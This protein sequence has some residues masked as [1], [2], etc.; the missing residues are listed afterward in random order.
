MIVGN[1]SEPLLSKY[2]QVPTEEA[3]AYA[4]A[5]GFLFMEVS[6]YTGWNVELAFGVLVTESV[7]MIEKGGG[8]GSSA[9]SGSSGGSGE[10]GGIGRSTIRNLGVLKGNTDGT[11]NSA[12]KDD[13]KFIE[14]DE[15]EDET[16]LAALKGAFVTLSRRATK[17]I[18]STASSSRSSSP[19]VQNRQQEQQQPSSSIAVQTPLSPPM[20]PNQLHSA[21]SNEIPNED[22]HVDYDYESEEDD[23]DLQQTI[24]TTMQTI[25]NSFKR[26]VNWVSQTTNAAV[27]NSFPD[28]NLSH[29]SLLNP[30]PTPS[31]LDSPFP[32]FPSSESTASSSNNTSFQNSISQQLPTSPSLDGA[33]RAQL[34][35]EQAMREHRRQMA[36]QTF[37]E[38]QTQIQTPMHPSEEPVPHGPTSF[39]PKPPP[40]PGPPPPAV[41]QRRATLKA[42]AASSSTRTPS[43]SGPHRPPPPRG[44]PPKMLTSSSGSK[45][46]SSITSSK[47]KQPPLP[48]P[49]PPPPPPSYPPPKT[50]R[51]RFEMDLV[52]LGGQILPL[53]SEA[54]RHDILES[55]SRNHSVEAAGKEVGDVEYGTLAEV[56]KNK[57]SGLLARRKTEGAQNL[58]GGRKAGAL[59]I[60]P[61]GFGLGERLLQRQEVHQQ[62]QRLEEHH[63]QKGGEVE[64]QEIKKDGIMGAAEE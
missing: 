5:Q 50:S 53:A 56:A 3:Q 57:K 23:I 59:G 22:N 49:P 24:N 62:K 39:R 12:L 17:I 58:K 20:S 43:S 45:S 64:G 44:P 8:R 7:Y 32:S 9:I 13:F 29:P 60:S 11:T 15:E 41:L 18:S 63:E 35:L 16:P 48:P 19:A 36:L 54:D 30:S 42:A 25:D 28:N 1:K 47:P 14:R 26:M 6:A 38:T 34:V 52:S 21:D 46:A 51:S 61:D 33:T 55:S 37:L 27:S 10:R 4:L 2:R 31:H 40:P